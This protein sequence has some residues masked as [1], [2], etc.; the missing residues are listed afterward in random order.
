MSSPLPTIVICCIYVY[1]VKV[2]G[3]NYMKDR[4]PIDLTR[5]LVFYNS[6]QVLLSAYIF[7]QGLRAGWWFDYSFRC[8]PVDKSD[9]PKAAFMVH[10]VWAFY[11]SKFTEFIDTFCFIARKKFSQVSLLH[12]YHHGVMPVS[13][14]FGLR[15][16]PGG[17]G[18]LLGLINAFVHVVMYSYYLLAGLGPQYQKYLWWKQYLTSMQ[19]IQFVIIIG[20]A[21]QLVFY[22]DCDFPVL[23]AYFVI[24]QTFIILAMFAHFYLRAYIRPKSIKSKEA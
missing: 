18:T 13:A 4:K 9:N 5:F 16:V 3:P 7:I 12:V 17:H 15:Y 2:W 22:D 24:C 10:C 21:V 6:F 8:Q 19:M 1:L 14:W 23:F 11:M 20:H